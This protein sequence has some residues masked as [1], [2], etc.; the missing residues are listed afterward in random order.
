MKK[1]LVIFVSLCFI[2]S[3][4]GNLSAQKAK[5]EKVLRIVY[6][7]KPDSWYQE[8]AKL[9]K[10]EIDKNP[11]NVKAWHNYYNA[12]RYKS[13]V[14]TI[15]NESKKEKL[16]Q[17]VA[18]LGKHAPESWEYNYLYYFNGCLDGSKEISYLKKAYEID[19]TRP[20]VL[21]EFISYYEINGDEGKITEF[22]KKL[23]DSKDI[24]PQLIDYNYNVLMSTEE[25]SILFTNGDNDTYPARM[26]QEAKGIRTD[27]TILNASLIF[28]GT[29]LER[30]LK[31]IGI[32]VKRE[33]IMKIAKKI[34]KDKSG[35]RENYFRLVFD[36]IQAQK[37]D[38]PI[39]FASTLYQNYYE[40][41]KDDTYIV[42]LAF[43]YSKDRIDNIAHIK[44]NFEKNY[45]L[46]H[47]RND[48]YDE[49]APIKSI[50][51]QT[52]NNYVP[53]LILL[54]EHYKNSGETEKIEEIKKI[55]YD[56]AYAAGRNEIIQYFDQKIK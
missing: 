32:D 25:N 8:Q 4:S 29:Y 48:W 10:Q 14:K 36:E 51:A 18:D 23:Y 7:V 30:N 17:I 15:D 35:F 2:L 13:F 46:D 33:K 43:R 1:S 3:L 45:R 12:V 54:A 27:V 40:D 22:F 37:P 44:K 55:V 6:E 56:I 28:A 5:P 31:K 52:N 47:L 41:M 20:D 38:M 49:D 19:P 53:P 50:M 16:F 24:A 11:Q 34:T 42:G 9:W 21:Y 26:L 39:Y